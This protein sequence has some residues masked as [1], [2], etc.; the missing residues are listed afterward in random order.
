MAVLTSSTESLPA[1][2]PC[3]QPDD[4]EPEGT[5]LSRLLLGSKYEIGGDVRFAQAYPNLSFCS[6]LG[7]WV[8]QDLERKALWRAPD[9]FARDEPLE[10]IGFGSGG[11][12]QELIVLSQLLHLGFSKLSVTLID[13]NYRTDKKS[14]DQLR[15]FVEQ[16]LEARVE[17]YIQDSLD[18]YLRQRDCKTPAIITIFDMEKISGV[19]EVEGVEKRGK[20]LHFALNLLMSPGAFPDESLLVY[21]GSEPGQSEHLKTVT[22]KERRVYLIPHLFALNSRP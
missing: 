2:Q 11:C 3:S 14:P 6:C 21:N 22:V 12:L 19:Y 5:E 10:F 1:T 17:V 16:E 9:L 4:Y 15:Q 20:L 18:V 13:K 8:R 7:V